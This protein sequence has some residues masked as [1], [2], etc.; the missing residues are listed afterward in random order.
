MN[1]KVENNN[2]DIVIRELKISIKTKIS[3]KQ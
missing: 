3:A 1:T 2:Y